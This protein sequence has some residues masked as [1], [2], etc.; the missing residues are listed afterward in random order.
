MKNFPAISP[1]LIGMILLTFIIPVQSVPVNASVNPAPVLLWSAPTGSTAFMSD[2]AAKVACSG[3]GMQVVA[4]YGAGIA[5]LRDRQGQVLWRWQSSRPYYTVRQ[6]TLSRDGER[7][8]LVLYDPLQNNKGEFDYFDRAGNL[9]WT[10]PLK[11]AFGFASLSGDGGVVALGDGNR[12]SFFNT[13]GNRIGTTVL[14]GVPW[15]VAI[16]DDGSIAAAGINK[17]DFSGN[18]YAIGQDGTILWS[19][20]TRYRFEETAVSGDGG[21][22]AGTESNRLRYFTAGGDR[23]FSFNSSPKFS[24]IAVSDNG[25]YIAASSQYYLRYFNASGARLW[26]YEVPSLPTRSGPYVGHLTMSG[27]GGYIS[28]TTEGNR[29][30]FFDRSGTILWQQENPSWIVSTCLSRNGKFLAQGTEQEI[31]Y[32]DTGIEVPADEPVP[33]EIASTDTSSPTTT[34]AHQAPVPVLVVPLSVLAG[35]LALGGTGRKR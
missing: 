16:S 18:L 12:I 30:L 25:A 22:I 1:F 32:F 24:G 13:T 31:R 5:E 4:G 7:A 26:Q 8:G 21:Y 10:Y 9:L 6:V 28:V 19:S 2:H 14:E 29:T 34:P 11:N 20:S 35:I 33:G 15:N 3:D 17:R 27:D 23:L